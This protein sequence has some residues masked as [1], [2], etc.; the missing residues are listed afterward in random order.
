MRGDPSLSIF[1][2]CA[3][4]LPDNRKELV[5]GI[6]SVNH[7]NSIVQIVERDRFFFK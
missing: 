4:S 5:E 7:D 3:I 6:M 1:E 2:W